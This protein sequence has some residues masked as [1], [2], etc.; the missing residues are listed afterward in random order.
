MGSWRRVRKWQ[1]TL[2]QTGRGSESWEATLPKPHENVR[3][4]DACS[5]PKNTCLALSKVRNWSW[6]T[7]LVENV[8]CR[9]LLPT[10]DS[11]RTAPL[12]DL[13][14]PAALDWLVLFHLGERHLHSFWNS[15]LLFCTMMRSKRDGK[16]E[17]RNGCFPLEHR[18]VLAGPWASPKLLHPSFRLSLTF[19]DQM[20]THCF[21]WKRNVT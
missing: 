21:K 5:L 4:M 1:C 19:P 3:V 16:V 10:G 6:E 18:G 13:E 9:W 11:Q 20:R 17:V 15:T 14:L 7:I 2:L 12:A 8:R